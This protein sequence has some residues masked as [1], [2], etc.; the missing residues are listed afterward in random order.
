MRS[1]VNSNESET[2]TTPLMASSGHIAVKPDEKALGAFGLIAVAYFWVSG[3]MYGLESIMSFGPPAY[4][5]AVLLVTPLVY[6][7]PI[8]IIT[9]D[10][11]V[12]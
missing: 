4:V 6:C 11:A 1:T 10:C 9:T 2:D 3:G 5:F 7:I 12:A 8:A